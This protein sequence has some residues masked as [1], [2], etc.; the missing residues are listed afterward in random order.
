MELLILKISIIFLFSWNILYEKIEKNYPEKNVAQTTSSYIVQLLS[1]K[2]HN[3]TP[4]Y[5]VSVKCFFE[6]SE[7]VV[8]IGVG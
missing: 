1:C 3:G 4:I 7:C 5:C 2:C 8:Q 6:Y